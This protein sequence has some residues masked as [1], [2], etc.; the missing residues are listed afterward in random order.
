MVK[1][2]IIAEKK[3]Q[4]QGYAKAL[5]RAKKSGDTFFATDSLHIAYCAGHLF[6]I[7]N[8]ARVS[9][10]SRENLP[11]YPELED[12]TFDYSET[13][14]ASL[15]RLK[16]QLFKN[17][18]KEIAWC[19]EIIIGTDGDREGESIFYTMIDKIPGARQKIKYRLWV[20]T[21]TKAGIQKA[22]ANLQDPEATYGH[23]LAAD[24]RR[25]A[26]WLIGVANLTP[27]V[28]H[29]LRELGK[30]SSSKVKG[31][32]VPEKISVGRILLPI[33]KLIIDRE[34]EIKAHQPKKFWKLEL[35][36]QFGT[37]FTSSLIFG[38]EENEKTKAEAQVAFEALETEAVV[39]SVLQKD[40]VKSAPHLFNLTNL[41]KYMSD[42]HGIDSEKTQKTAEGLRLREGGADGYLS[43]PRTD[44]LYITEDEFL[45]LK[46]NLKALKALIGLKFEPE[47]LEPRRRYVDETKTNPHYALI[48]TETLPDLDTLSHLEKKVYQE[49]AKRTLLMFAGDKKEAKTEVDLSL[50]SCGA[51]FK[52]TG[53]Q[54]LEEGWSAL[55]GQ[56]TKD[57]QL[58]PYH[59][60]QVLQLSKK[61]KEGLTKA[62]PSHTEKTLLNRMNKLSI[63]TSSTRA[64]AIN[65]L[66]KEKYLL[67]NKKGE[68]ESTEK[69]RKIIELLENQGSKFVD[70][71]MT[72]NWEIMLKL[73]EQGNK[74]FT[75][76]NFIAQVQ[77]ELSRTLKG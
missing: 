23:Y 22:Y 67:V 73:I 50:A 66:K 60:G 52:A 48:P 72:K 14:D 6:G 10:K 58:P 19:D 36:D 62:P 29:R 54:V 25:K 28:R 33:M 75:P 57:K 35:I 39:S 15:T 43:Y 9:Y 69:A 12:Y 1:R 47:N 70:L 44:S 2:L 3:E 30:L 20:G 61:L 77:E 24:A 71:E 4:A 46:A 74:D 53:T 68:F 27:Y 41:Q 32:E 31:K 17:L 26:D 8:D 37:I 76:E 7:T 16:K 63:G 56:K 49:V 38:G 51:S 11:L 34:R 59:E 21:S 18:K 65:R 13:Q 64:A 55:E 45:Y 42:K 5:G 40:E